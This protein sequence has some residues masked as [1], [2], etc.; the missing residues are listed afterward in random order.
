MLNIR[1]VTNPQRWFNLIFCCKLRSL[2]I[3][4]SES[5]LEAPV[6]F[7]LGYGGVTAP[8]EDTDVNDDVSSFGGDDQQDEEDSVVV[9]ERQARFVAQK[10]VLLNKNKT[11]K[12][13]SFADQRKDVQNDKQSDPP[14]VATA[15]H[16]ERS[17]SPEKKSDQVADAAP[18]QQE[19]GSRSAMESPSD[20]RICCF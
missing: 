15:E 4:W 14:Q 7:Q 11:R 12:T 8:V 16:V 18:E 10:R 1:Y 9:E 20:R 19:N 13:T 3:K 5:V 17:G 2:L 6:L